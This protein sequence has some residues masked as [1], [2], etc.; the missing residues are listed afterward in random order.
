MPD[1]KR[2]IELN[3]KGFSQ[4]SI[5]TSVRSSRNTI[6]TVVSAAKLK[7][8]TYEKV[9]DL[10]N[11]QIEQTLGL[12]YSR[13]GKPSPLYQMPDYPNYVKE[14]KKPGVTIRMVWEEYA[15]T[16]RKSEK[17]PYQLTQFKKYLREYVDE[18]EFTDIINH[19]PGEST[20]VDWAGTQP[21]WSDPVTGEVIKG[22]LFVGVLS[23]SGYGYC[24]AT[25]DMKEEA[26]IKCHV[27]MF[28]YFNGITR[29][30]IPDNLRAGVTSH[31]K[32]GDVILN[33]YY[34]EMADHYGIAILPARVY[35]PKDKSRAENLVKQFTRQIIGRLRNHVF[36]SIDEYN[37]AIK[38]KLEEFNN[39]PF[40]KKPGSRN[41]GYKEELPYLSPLPAYPYEFA[42]WKKGKVQTNSHIAYGKRYYS[43]PHEYIGCEVDLRI[44]DQTISV[45]HKGIKLCCHPLLKGREG[46][47][48]TQPEHMPEGSNAREQWSKERFIKWANRIGVATVQVITDLFT[49]YS[50]EQQAYNG[51]K[52]IL[53]LADRY[54]PERVEAACGIALKHLNRIRYRDILGILK[55]EH[56]IASQRQVPL[57]TAPP[58][59]A[60]SP[61]LRGS[62]YYGKGDDHE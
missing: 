24:E 62:S 50:Y 26:W 61:Y 28:E 37:A 33:R 11:D 54:T 18:R 52:S 31:P 14:L 6:R 17:V 51:A 22:Y 59:K 9:K 3:E 25:A 1:Y 39:A 56:D 38:E 49:Q 12:S 42:V 23:Y 36:F 40:Q 7:G 41:S 16:C 4:R 45:Y 47:Y 27:H 58:D 20:E 34:E 8:L 43:V 13:Q 2:I 46:A 19:K 48:S 35:H 60:S 53:L 55:H 32:E 57:N 10:S 5:E 30:L 21:Y 29:F 44:G 15:N